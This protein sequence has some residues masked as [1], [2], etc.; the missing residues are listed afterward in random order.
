MDSF[1][2][3][4]Q[5]EKVVA[6]CHGDM[7]IDVNVTFE[8][9]GNYTLRF[10]DKSYA[11]SSDLKTAETGLCESYE[12]DCMINDGIYKSKSV[13]S[14]PNDLHVF[15]NEGHVELRLPQPKWIQETVTHGMPT[16]G[17]V[18]PMPGVVEKILV[19]PGD[20]VHHGQPLVVLVAMKME[21]VIK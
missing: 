11:V 15:S 2:I 21:Y 16:G 1:R 18:A 6:L 4:L 13:W 12:F 14:T 17:S 9:D 8:R 10:G 7:K 5:H 20:D 19:A 3:N